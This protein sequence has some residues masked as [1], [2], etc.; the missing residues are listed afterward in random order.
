M[1]SIP[2]EAEQVVIG[3]GRSFTTVT[4][5]DRLRAWGPTHGGRLLQ[6]VFEQLDGEDIDPMSGK[7]RKILISIQSDLLKQADKVAEERGTNRSGLIAQALK[8]LLT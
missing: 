8:A 6:V 2:R 4:R 5:N 3:A 1:A 7:A